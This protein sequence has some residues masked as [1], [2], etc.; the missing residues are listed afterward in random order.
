MVRK[1]KLLRTQTPTNVF[2]IKW[3]KNNLFGN[4]F[5]EISIPKAISIN[6]SSKFGQIFPSQTAEILR[7][8][9][10]LIIKSFKK[11]KLFRKLCY[12]VTSHVPVVSR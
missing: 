2:D 5:Y 8:H 7:V 12:R 9:H 4:F 3:F 1:L 11:L 6:L 10:Q